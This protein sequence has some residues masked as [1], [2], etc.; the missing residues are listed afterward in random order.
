MRSLSN[1]AL[2]KGPATEKSAM[3]FRS[4]TCRLVAKGL[5]APD[6]AIWDN[7]RNE[8]IADLDSMDGQQQGTHP[9]LLSW[10]EERQATKKAGHVLPQYNGDKTTAKKEPRRTNET[11]TSKGKGR[12]KGRED[13]EGD[14][15]TGS[16]HEGNEPQRDTTCCR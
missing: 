3:A 7:L 4:F 2:R 16:E 14:N 12:A 6:L 8:F 10:I 11:R 9:G 15:G 5:P 13:E 1:G